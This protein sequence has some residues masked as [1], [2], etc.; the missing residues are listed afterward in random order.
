MTPPQAAC[1]L[2][3]CCLYVFPVCIMKCQG[4]RLWLQDVPRGDWYCPECRPKQVRSRKASRRKSFYEEE[5]SN[6]GEDEETQADD[7][8]ANPVSFYIHLTNHSI[9]PPDYTVT[10][11]ILW[12][13]YTVTCNI[14]CYVYTVTCNILW[15]VYTVTC[16]ILWYVYTV[17]CNILW[18][19]YTLYWLS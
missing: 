19:V 16:N 1:L 11:N 10:C 15:Y 8:L 18:Y 9:M 12:Y 13:V 7:R 3:C 6:E 4:H 2:C 5:E 17:T 14:L